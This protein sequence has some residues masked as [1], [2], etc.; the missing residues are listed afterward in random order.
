MA[1]AS[2]EQASAL[3]ATPNGKETSKDLNSL[4]GSQDEQLDNIELGP[5]ATYLSSGAAAGITQEH[6]DYLIQRHG[7]LDLDPIPSDDP[8]GQSML[9]DVG[10]S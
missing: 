9:P 6:R 4:P 2:R 10:R 7:T 8:A 5:R 1:E 3:Q